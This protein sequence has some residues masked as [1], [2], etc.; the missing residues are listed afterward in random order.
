MTRGRVMFGAG[1]GLLASDALMMGIE[2]E[3]TRDRLQQGLD[4]ILRLFRGE[5]VTEETDW[6]TM[7][8]ARTHLRPYTVPYPEV[9]VASAVTPSAGRLAGRYDLGMLC[10]AAGER[11]GFNALD[12]N[13]KVACEI[14]AEDGRDMDRGR[15]RCV[16]NMHLGDSKEQAVADIRYGCEE[17]IRYFNNNQPRF[18]VPDGADYVDWV[19]KHEVAVV[20]TPDDAIRRIERL[21]EKQGEFGCL[22]LQIS[23][24]ADWPALKRSVELYA[25]YVI[26]HFAGANRNRMDSYRWVTENQ[27]EIVA[28]RV[29]A[30]QQMFAKHQ[31]EW[32]ER[33][34]AETPDQVQSSVL[35]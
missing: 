33:G 25:Q 8:D 22:L 18:D 32:A 13:W 4:V 7:R 3:V 20:G 11:A 27:D 19:V 5:T 35:S 9:C 26:P 12:T 15:V 2:P 14:A 16:V 31:A 21:Y 24:W 30:A 6:Y 17:S 29:G 23:N 10:V 28:K 34:A 1:P